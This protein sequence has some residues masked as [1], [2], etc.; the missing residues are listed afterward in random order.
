MSVNHF[1]S[2]LPGRLYTSRGGTDAKD[3][4]HGGCIFV[5]HA[6]GYIQVRH[7]VS[8]SAEDTLKAK[9]MYERDA[10]NAGV[11]IKAYHT[12]NGVFTSKDFMSQLLEDNQQIRFSGA[13][14]A[15]QNGVAERGIQ[16]VV[17]MARTMLIHAAMRSPQGTITAELWPMAIDHAVWIYNRIP[18][19]DSGLSTFELWSRSSFL[20]TKEILS[21]CH[22]WG[23]PSYVLEPKLQKGGSHIPKW[24]PR[25]RRGAF[26]GFSRMHSTLVGLVLNLHTHSISPS[27][28]WC[29]MICLLQLLLLIMRLWCP[30]SG[31][32]LSPVPR[33]VFAFN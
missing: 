2:A 17:K 5:V 30:R 20:P 13:G 6:S 22:V 14:A 25:S 3:K 21:T 32:T 10:A 8:L 1:Q 26:M 23:C 12:D 33:L 16:T 31:L 7:Q 4:F 11:K 29:L 9:L 15:H 27:S 19:M 28:M 18:R 24:A